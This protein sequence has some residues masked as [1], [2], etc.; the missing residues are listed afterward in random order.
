[1]VYDDEKVLDVFA[2]FEEDKNEESPE[3]VEF[4]GINKAAEAYYRFFMEKKDKEN[5]LNDPEAE[6]QAR[7]EAEDWLYENTLIIAYHMEFGAVHALRD[8]GRLLQS[9]FDFLFSTNFIPV[10]VPVSMEKTERTEDEWIL[11]IKSAILKSAE[12]VKGALE[13]ELERAERLEEDGKI[14]LFKADSDIYEE[15]DEK[16]G[17]YR[18]IDIRSHRDYVVE[19][20]R[21][22]P[23]LF[24]VSLTKYN[25]VTG[26]E[27]LD[28]RPISIN[29]HERGNGKYILYFLDKKKM[30]LLGFNPPESYEDMLTT[31]SLN[32]EIRKDYYF[33]D[34]FDIQYARGITLLNSGKVRIFVFNNICAQMIVL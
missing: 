17:H 2:D 6:D 33:S 27:E 7:E 18:G 29:L 28:K 15:G 3:S 22:C 34:S 11:H 12:E 23:E 8:Y 13:E 16:W 9:P 5:I 31:D 24:Y 30:A 10:S 1:M 20:F 21:D 26:D 19:K 25:Y 14:V 32:Y 4:E